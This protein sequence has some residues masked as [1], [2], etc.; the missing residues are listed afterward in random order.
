MRQE[1]SQLEV[2]T[3]ARDTA[4]TELQAVS[5][6]LEAAEHNITELETKL[7]AA[8]NANEKVLM[9]MSQSQEDTDL[10]QRQLAEQQAKFVEAEQ[11][12]QQLKT[13]LAIAQKDKNEVASDR[14]SEQR[15]RLKLQTEIAIKEDQIGGILMDNESLKIKNERIKKNCDELELRIQKY[16]ENERHSAQQLAVATGPLLV[17]IEE[18]ESELKTSRF[19]YNNVFTRC[20]NL[21]AAR[22]DSD[23]IKKK[24]EVKFH[25]QHSE[26]I[27]VR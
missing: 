27:T 21:E 22:E 11:T 3:T 6:K 15:A 5:K 9:E 10:H 23:A 17:R 26:I 19:E 1:L 25:E 13:E 16:M 24:F 20:K 14:E 18:L 12:I 4:I 2:V 8:E 7:D